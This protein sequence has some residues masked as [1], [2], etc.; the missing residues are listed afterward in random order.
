MSHSPLEPLNPAQR[1]QAIVSQF[2]AAL[3]IQQDLQ[4]RGYEEKFDRMREET[5]AKIS[6]I[7]KTRHTLNQELCACLD[8]LELKNENLEIVHKENSELD[9]QYAGLVA[10][11]RKL[12][13]L[14]KRLE[15]EESK[16]ADKSA[17]DQATLELELAQL[18]KEKAD[19][20]ETVKDLRGFLAM[21]GKL[22][23]LDIDH[24][25]PVITISRRK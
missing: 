21:N 24:S 25:A 2:N 10:D 4:R 3:A 20:R 9:S 14:H 1:W 13:D 16:R 18:D 12:S 15:Q 5:S 17:S 7:R 23:K 6:A 8:A 22:S 11:L 19:L